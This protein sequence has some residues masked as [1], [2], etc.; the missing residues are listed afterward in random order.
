MLVIGG[1]QL[2]SGLRAYDSYFNPARL[3]HEIA[4]CILMP[5]VPPPGMPTTSNVIGGPV[6][7]GLDRDNCWAAA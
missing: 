3:H 7:N 2:I 1:R 4:Q 5:R 6:L